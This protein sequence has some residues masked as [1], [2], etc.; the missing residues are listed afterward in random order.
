M[1]GLR[2]AWPSRLVQRFLE[3]AK[4]ERPALIDEHETLTFATLHERAARLAQAL[5]ARG[6]ARRRIA[7]LAPSD[8]SWVEAFWA[9]CL[10]G[11]T[12]VPISPLYPAPEQTSLLQ[13]S[14]AAA[15]L[16]SETGPAGPERA[17]LPS[18]RFARG[19]L[20]DANAVPAFEPDVTPASDHDAESTPALLLFTSGTT[21]APKGVPLSHGN[22]LAGAEILGSAWGLGPA[23]RLLHTLPL[24]HV[25]GICVALLSTLLA[26]GSVRLLPRYDASRV[27]E[28]LA[29]ASVLMGVPTQ[30]K[31][32]VEHIE[33]L[34]PD[35]AARARRDLAALRLITSGSAKLPESLGRR[36]EQL[37]GRYPLERYG[38]SEVG[39]VLG[40]PLAGPRQPG[41]C[42]RA[43]PRCDV[44]VVDEHGGEL[45]PGSPGELW[46]RG[47]TVFAGYDADP[48]ASAEAFANG[49]FKSGDTAVQDA[50]GFVR[51][52][53][54]T[55]IDIIKS[56]GYKLSAL[57][58]EE[59]L[60]QHPGVREAAVVGIADETW[61]ERVVAAIVPSKGAQDASLGEAV[62]QWLRERV[63]GYKVPKQIVLVAEL[64]RNSM[65]KVLKPELA[66]ALSSAAS[67]SA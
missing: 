67:S 19:A 66:R 14:R 58:I 5:H 22:V 21:G 43:L 18:L 61:G 15:L 26:G 32:L 52:L 33:R 24:H 11:G 12:V 16:L 45:A 50:D 60:L 25:H 17:T 65:G 28:G 20:L 30:H 64:P 47:P 10:A 34:P 42:G 31:L 62:R 27:L 9:I 54:R 63:A 49:F 3:L 51:L 41:S 48:R 46:I 2:S 55:S 39:I 29:Q 40:N 57:E 38:M 44:R 53:G 35:D 56:G 4:C 7:L 23:D 37:S 8:A 13:R 36:L 59:H 6:L 1:E